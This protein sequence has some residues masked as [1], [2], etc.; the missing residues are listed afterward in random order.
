M[1]TEI[2]RKFLLVNDDWRQQVQ[3]THR[4]RQG[5]LVDVMN[6]HATASVRV[7]IEDDHANLN[8]KSAEIGIVR[9]EYEYA[10]PLREAEQILDRL[11]HRPCIEK[12]R[13]IVTGQDFIWEIDEFFGDNEGLLVAEIELESVH[14]GFIRPP[15]LGREVTDDPRYYNVNLIAQPYSQWR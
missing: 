4:I 2:E 1:A 10:I 8:I 6:E 15:W 14:Q 12:H 11:C 3:R 13:H 5:Y 9:D 7:R